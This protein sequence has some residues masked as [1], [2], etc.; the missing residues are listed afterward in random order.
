MPQNLQNHNPQPDSVT[1]L[2]QALLSPIGQQY[3]LRR[4]AR[5]DDIG[6]SF[7]TWNWA[8]SLLTLNWL[9]FRG[10]WSWALAYACA[11]LG[12]ALAVFGIGKLVFD[13]TDATLHALLGVFLAAAFMLPGLYA[14][15]LYHKRCKRQMAD[16]ILATT[17][18]QQA[19][20]VLARQAPKPRRLWLLALVNLGLLAPL[21]AV[22]VMFL[23]LRHGDGGAMPLLGGGAPTTSAPAS[24]SSA[25]SPPATTAPTGARAVGGSIAEPPDKPLAAPLPLPP[26]VE[27]TA[28][29]APAHAEPVA[30]PVP[31]PAAPAIPV[32]QAPTAAPAMAPLAVAPAVVA[33]SAQAA[34]SKYFVDAG[35]YA[36]TANAQRAVGKLKASKLPV[37]A[38]VLH[39]TRGPRTRVRVGPFA[40]QAQAQQAASTIHALGLPAL[41]E[42]EPTT[43]SQNGKGH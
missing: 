30:P 24:A 23:N 10:L 29:A 25:A 1:A 43:A 9:L 7:P 27:T 22:L 5:F 2:Y 16:A 34:T 41:V 17:D 31:Q 18:N 21:I 6:R 20:Q 19:L 14:N 38:E 35:I 37:V 32:A 11:A 4:F 39:M 15:A 36:Q 33:A 26:K 40:T 13:F 12:V 3:Y 8:A 28:S 42:P